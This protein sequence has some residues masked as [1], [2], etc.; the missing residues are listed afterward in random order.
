M[1]DWIG[2][3]QAVLASLLGAAIGGSAVYWRLVLRIQ[4]MESSLTATDKEV[5]YGKNKLRDV[6]QRLDRH[7]DRMAENDA[8]FIGIET[9]LEHISTTL[10]K[11][12]D[13]LD[14]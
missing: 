9:K 12:V 10:D 7:R 3:V 2:I 5:E 11:L 13:K 6:A 1:T 14:S 4:K 8:R